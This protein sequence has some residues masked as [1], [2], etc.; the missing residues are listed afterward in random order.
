MNKYDYSIFINK[1]NEYASLQRDN[2]N[3][4]VLEAL[5]DTINALDSMKKLNLQE[6]SLYLQ[7]LSAC[8][9]ASCIKHN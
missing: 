4:K 7:I 6:S 8:L 1:L 3:E 2:S 9:A 5:H